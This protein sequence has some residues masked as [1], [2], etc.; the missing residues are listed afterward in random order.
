MKKL[1]IITIL[2]VF[3]LLA[4]CV[5]VP[6]D[7][8]KNDFLSKKFEVAPNKS[9][10]YIYRDS[11]FVGSAILMAV[12]I[13][14]E[15]LGEL[16]P[17]TYFVVSVSPGEHHITSF[18]KSTSLKTNKTFSAEPPS[19]LETEVSFEKTSEITLTTKQGKNYYIWQE[20]VIGFVSPDA[21]LHE[22]TQNQGKTAI[23]SGKLAKIV[24]N[25]EN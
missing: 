4:G 13:N 11:R 19:E 6:M 14:G 23:S 25:I 9:N 8:V 24:K 21:Q 2:T 7:S 5:S 10:I 17:N 16:A 1:L 22:V 3:G 18:N 12:A 20:P 15:I